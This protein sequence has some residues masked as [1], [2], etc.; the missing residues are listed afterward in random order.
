M[1]FS[2]LFVI[3]ALIAVGIGCNAQS[4]PLSPGLQTKLDRRIKLTIRAQY[5]VPPDYNVSLG[6]RTK[7][8]ISGYDT[9][10][11]TFKNGKGQEK[12][13]NF[14][15]SNDNNT[16]ARLEKFDLTANPTSQITTLGRPI[17]GNPNAKVTIIVFDDLECPFCARMNE[18]LFPETEKHYGSMVRYIYKNFPLPMHPWAMHA[19]VDVNCLAAQSPTGYWNLVDY[20]HQHDSEI[21]G[22]RGQQDVATSKLR[23]DEA[24]RAEGKKQQV[25]MQKLNAC[26][27]KQDESQ[28]RKSMQEGN[29]LGID[30]TPTLF[31]NGER[32]NGAVS[33]SI[34]WT[35]I[36]RAITDAG[37]T[38][39]PVAGTSA[40][41][42]TAA[43]AQ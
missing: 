6:Q 18:T 36:D 2:R 4:V 38:P 32:A 13:T 30:G 1:R 33:Q 14:L 26:I 35:M 40:A 7:S 29:A 43:P 21:S 27:T 8:N 39:P 5:N 11:V 31:V 34:L 23:V 16:L 10:P 42:A 9:L 15:I 17:R 19:A 20:I 41:Q 37:E 28:V 24:T 22:E 25:D 12:T 3:L